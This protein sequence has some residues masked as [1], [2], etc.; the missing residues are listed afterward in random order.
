MAR[1]LARTVAVPRPGA[2]G[3]RRPGDR[4]RRRRLPVGGQGLEL[5]VELVDPVLERGGFLLAVPEHGDDGAGDDEG[6]QDVREDAH[7]EAAGTA[8]AGTRVV[9][10]VPHA[11][12]PFPQASRFQRGTVALVAS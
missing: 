3:H 5:A 9:A 11:W 10:P 12:S 7:G 8:D 2:L 4:L 6:A 1:S